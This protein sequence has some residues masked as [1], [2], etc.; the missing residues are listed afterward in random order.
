MSEKSKE[1]LGKAIDAV[2]A[3]DHLAANDAFSGAIKDHSRN[4]IN[5][6]EPKIEVDTTADDTSTE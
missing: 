4:I 3:G 5:P 2:R 1:F 6:P